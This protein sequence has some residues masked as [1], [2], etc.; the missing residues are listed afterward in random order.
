MVSVSSLTAALAIVTTFNLIVL[1]GVMSL[2]ARSLVD[3]LLDGLLDVLLGAAAGILALPCILGLGAHV[4]GRGLRGAAAGILWMASF[5][6]CTS[7]WSLRCGASSTGGFV[8]LNMANVSR[9]LQRAWSPRSCFGRDSSSDMRL[10][11]VPHASLM[12]EVGSF[13]MYF[14]GV[15]S[16]RLLCNELV[17]WPCGMACGIVLRLGLGHCRHLGDLRGDCVGLRC[18][19]VPPLLVLSMLIIRGLLLDG[20]ILVAQLALAL[21]MCSSSS[22]SM[23]PVLYG[24]D[25]VGSARLLLRAWAT[26]KVNWESFLEIWGFP[27]APGLRAR[28]AP[29]GPGPPGPGPGPGPGLGPVSRSL[30][31]AAVWRSVLIVCVTSLGD[32]LLVKFVVYIAVTVI[33]HGASLIAC[34]YL[35]GNDF[36]DVQSFVYFA[37]QILERFLFVVLESLILLDLVDA[38]L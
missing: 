9:L 19:I 36:L 1:D 11:I 34:I 8:V 3:G 10:V 7:S 37:V 27:A 29:L 21:W 20:V 31:D 4:L 38:D 5:S 23:S 6:S 35:F 24:G 17:A 13:L 2:D 30:S 32:D 12:F 33:F 22:S 26:R 28:G 14:F 16:W 18:R 25:L 15:A